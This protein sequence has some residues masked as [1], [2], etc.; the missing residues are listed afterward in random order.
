VDVIKFNQRI[1]HGKLDFHPTVKYGFEDPD[2]APYFKACGWADDATGDADVVVT[3]GEL[4]IDPLTIWGDGPD[5]GKFVQPEKVAEHLNADP[6]KVAA[7]TPSS[8]EKEAFD[9]EV[10]ATL[11]DTA[12]SA[13]TS[14]GT[15]DA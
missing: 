1:K 10:H 9:A 15:A 3:I 13:S 4:D 2:A 8:L 12:T 7:F 5:K 11:R 6:D 14:K